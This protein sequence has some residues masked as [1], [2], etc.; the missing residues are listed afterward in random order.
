[1]MSF[2][3]VVRMCHCRI[4]S[5]LDNLPDNVNVATTHLFGHYYAVTELSQVI[6]Y[7]PQT[8][9]T[10]QHIDLTDIHQGLISMT[11]HPLYDSDGTYWNMGTLYRF[12]DMIANGGSV[13]AHVIMKISPPKTKQEKKNPWLSL[14]IVA[15][16]PSPHWMSIPYTHSFFMTEN[17]LVLPHQPV[18]TASIPDFH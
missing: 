17:Y 4:S 12:S 8:L 11:V 14:E 18:A 15:K 5:F 6:E 3:K 10:L 13:F 1:M 16:I 9:E 2:Y 7:N